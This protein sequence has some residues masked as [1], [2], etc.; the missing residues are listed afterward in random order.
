ML[1]V[2]SDSVEAKLSTQRPE[3]DAERF[4]GSGPMPSVPFECRQ[5]GLSF[6]FRQTHLTW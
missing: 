4:G 1:L 5:N 3:T 2:R 6:E